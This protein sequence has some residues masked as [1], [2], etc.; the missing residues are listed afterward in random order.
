[1]GLVGGYLAPLTIAATTPT[2]LA[3]PRRR[4]R[5]PGSFMRDPTTWP[6][7]MS[8][9][10]ATMTQAP[11]F[12]YRLCAERWEGWRAERW[13]ASPADGR[14]TDVSSVDLSR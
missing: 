5:D 6:L 3:G 1:M 11:D 14:E 8:K 13:R 2:L 4:V 9:Y 7:I 12:A 10:R